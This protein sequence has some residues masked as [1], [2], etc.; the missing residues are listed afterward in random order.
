MDQPIM[1]STG[2]EAR[3]DIGPGK[4]TESDTELNENWNEEQAREVNEAND[5]NS[6]LCNNQEYPGD[7]LKKCA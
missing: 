2:T 5:I 4:D 7:Q 6:Q 3:G 1:P